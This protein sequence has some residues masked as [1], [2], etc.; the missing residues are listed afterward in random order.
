MLTEAI[1]GGALLGVRNQ[2]VLMLYY[3]CHYHYH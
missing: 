2:E 3:H 1:F